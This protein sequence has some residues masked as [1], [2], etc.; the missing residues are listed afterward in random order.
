MASVLR[1]V[2][3]WLGEG[4][5]MRWEMPQRGVYLLKEVYMAEPSEASSYCRGRDSFVVVYIV[6]SLEGGL[7]VVYGR[8]KPGVLGC[9]AATFT[10][11]FSR[12][13]TKAA[14]RTLI[15]F[16]TKVDKVPL[17]QINPDVI[18][19]AGLCDEYPLICEDPAVVINRLSADAPKVRRQVEIQVK[20]ET[21]AKSS[22]WLVEELARILR[23]KLELDGGFAEVL[24]R[25]IEDPDRL[26]ECVSRH[27]R[28]YV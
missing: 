6:A 27:G 1:E 12:A 28:G 2:E 21:S 14:V 8:V 5:R 17:F 24:K 15:D 9:P 25:V 7:D 23:D 26:R 10:R 11:R 16:A 19:F 18:R 3:T 20:P 13:E 4:W 22:L